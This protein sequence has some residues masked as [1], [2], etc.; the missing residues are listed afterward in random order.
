M[1]LEMS[2]FIPQKRSGVTD[3]RKQKYNQTEANESN[4]SNG[5]V[6]IKY[7]VLHQIDPTTLTLNLLYSKWQIKVC[8]YLRIYIRYM[9]LN[10]F[11]SNVSWFQHTTVKPLLAIIINDY[12]VVTQ[13][14]QVWNQYRKVVL[15][16]LQ[17]TATVTLFIHWHV[18]IATIH[19]TWFV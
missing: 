16:L 17:K 12:S 19:V 6:W 2:T 3:V 7:V 8:L 5:K 18:L 1:L 4:S 15:L 10:L 14:F 13:H 9:K 11:A